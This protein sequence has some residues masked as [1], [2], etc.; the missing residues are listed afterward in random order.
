M[1]DKLIKREKGWKRSDL[2]SRP[3]GE[4]EKRGKK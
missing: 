1:N 4:R 2:G 3:R